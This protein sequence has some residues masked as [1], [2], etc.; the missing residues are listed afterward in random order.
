MQGKCTKLQSLSNMVYNM[1]NRLLYGQ[2]ELECG[3]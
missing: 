1:L 3:K 2:A